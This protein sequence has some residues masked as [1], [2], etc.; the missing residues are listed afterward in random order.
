MAPKASQSSQSES[1]LRKS[2]RSTTKVNTLKLEAVPSSAKR[3]NP[4]TAFVNLPS[5]QP[6]PSSKG[7]EK[8]KTPTQATVRDGIHESQA[9]GEDSQLWV[10]LYEPTTEAELAVH[11]KK[12]EDVRRWLAEAFE[13]GPSGKLRKYRRILALTGPAG[14]AKTTTMRILAREMDFEIL[15]W[16]NSIGENAAIDTVSGQPFPENDPDREA[17]FS[18]FESFLARAS[19]CNNL[20]RD[21]A[22][23]VSSSQAA[24]SST[25]LTQ[26]NTNSNK[27][28]IILLEDLPNL[29]HN[30]TKDRFHAALQSLVVD[31]SPNP[32]PIVIIVS[33]TGMR[34]EASDER[35]SAGSTYR[36]QDSVIDVRTVLPKDMLNGPYVTQIRFNPIAPTFLRKALQALLD[37][38]FSTARGGNSVRPSKHI[39]DIIVDSANGDIRSAVNALQFS[40]I[41]QKGR[42]KGKSREAMVIMESVTRRE[43]S[44]ALF[45]LIGKVFY[46]KRKGD[47][48]ALSASKRDIEKEKALDESL[49]DPPDLPSFL[50]EHQ[51]RTSRVNVDIL[52]S[53]SPID[54]SLYSLYLHQNYTQ[55]CNDVD[56]CDGIADNLS[57]V[58]SSGGEAWY[59]ANPHRFHLLTLGTL[60]SLPTPVER[61]SQKIFKPEFFDYL[62]KEKDGWEGVRDVRRWLVE[63]VAAVEDAGWRT[64]GWS[65][66]DVPIELGGVLKARDASHY[67]T[68]IKGPPG[69]RSFSNMMFV[70]AMEGAA[71]Q[72][73]EA[74][75]DGR[76]VEDDVFLNREDETASRKGGWLESDDIEDF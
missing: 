33:D 25:T 42:K 18:K 57:W 44:L 73:G 9:Q 2:S 21:P 58:D 39:L 54:S 11:V 61:R 70:R 49:K 20:F 43:Q 19:T 56:E 7:K 53:D 16:R 10:D 69:H 64:G 23:L 40:S 30:G 68:V 12:V 13:G 36:E 34:G 1:L 37:R 72:L 50:S 45:H 31:P 41:G 35:L 8:E 26:T 60:H 51:R 3:I 29:L 62:N 47:P 15:E 67:V 48:P 55:F 66:T 59:Q 6:N 71:E 74:E 38:H 4:L 76:E 65:K 52:Y 63:K 22:P 75:A 17:L 28:R 27:R 32:V 24:S 46:N 5:S 14:T